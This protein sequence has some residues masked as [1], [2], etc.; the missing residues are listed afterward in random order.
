MISKGSC[1]S[2]IAISDRM[3]KLYLQ[4]VVVDKT[5]GLEEARKL[6]QEVIK[7]KKKNVYRETSASY[8]F[9]NIPKTKFMVGSFVSKKLNDTVTL[10]FGKLA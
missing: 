6:A 5:V 3:D 9:R 10:V 4:S 8:R 1:H 2:G 7:N